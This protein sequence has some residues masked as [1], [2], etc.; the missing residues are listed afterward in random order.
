MNVGYRRKVLC[1][2]V[3]MLSKIANRKFIHSDTY[4]LDECSTYKDGESDVN[5]F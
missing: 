4:A 5:A 1:A 3:T 2:C